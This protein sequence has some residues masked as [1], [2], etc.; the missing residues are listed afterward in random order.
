MIPILHLN[1]FGFGNRGVAF[2]QTALQRHST[3]N[4]VDDAAEFGQHSV[5]HKFEDMAVMAG[6]LR[7]EQFLAACTKALER[8]RLVALHLRGIAH[9]IGGK[10]CRKLAV[11]LFD[12]PT[13]L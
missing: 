9:D 6:D 10:N 7:L 12:L 5:A 3:F 13:R 4:R 2:S 8:A 1:P 11:H